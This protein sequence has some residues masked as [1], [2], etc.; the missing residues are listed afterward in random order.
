MC[1]DEGIVCELCCHHG[2]LLWLCKAILAV[3]LTKAVKGWPATAMCVRYGI[4]VHPARTQGDLNVNI[5]QTSQTG[6]AEFQTS[7]AC[8]LCG[9]F[10]Q[11]VPW[12]PLVQ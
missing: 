1:H 4:A 7:G 5:T 11:S 10:Q 9:G 6:C 12:W 8:P 3:I 2:P